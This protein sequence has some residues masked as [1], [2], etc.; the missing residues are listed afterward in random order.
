MAKLMAPAVLSN[1][2]GQLQ[3]LANTIMASLLGP[4]AVTYLY[5][6]F[7]LMQLPMGIFGVSIATASFPVIAGHVARNEINELK[8]TL[9]LGMRMNML[10]SMPA[11]LD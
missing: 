5:Y 10:I 6:G 8:H 4:A 2:V 3:V 7:R 11:T 1:S 9:S